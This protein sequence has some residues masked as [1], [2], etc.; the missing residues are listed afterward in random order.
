[1]RTRPFASRL[2]VAGARLLTVT[3]VLAGG[4]VLMAAAPA[5]AQTSSSGSASAVPVCIDSEGN[6]HLGTGA[7][8][9]P[10][11]MTSVSL[12]PTPITG[13]QSPPTTDASG[14]SS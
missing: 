13:A 3:A 11:G 14:S 8:T 9:C 12:Q 7:G 10:D 5:A 4:L 1:M 6:Y 2:A